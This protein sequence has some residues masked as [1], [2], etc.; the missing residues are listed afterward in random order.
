LTRVRLRD[1][2]ELALHEQ[3]QGPA[4]L[5]VHGF[6]GSQRA[7]GDAVIGALAAHGRVLAVDLLGHGASDR[8]HRAQRYDVR[9]VVA[10]LCDA[11]AARGA[12][13][14]LWIGYS[15]GARVALAAAV[16]APARVAGLVLEGGSPGLEQAAER[17]A[18]RAADAALAERLEREGIE[19]FVAHWMD[20]AIFATQRRLPARTR[21]AERSRRLAN[22]PLALAAC[23]RGLGTGAQ[24]SFWSSL[25]VIRAPALLVAG[26]HDAKYRELAV[27]MAARLPRAQ[28]AV[29][30][31]A[32][33]AAHLEEPERYLEAVLPHVERLQRTRME[34]SEGGLHPAGPTE[35]SPAR[36]E[37][38]AS[39]GGRHPAGRTREGATS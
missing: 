5:L 30:A 10:D 12:A 28:V 1:G 36:S 2:L 8:P 16:L 15:Q 25:A 26:E 37:P 38:E 29:I 39:E 14:A 34:A 4:L 6:T 20:L 22:D 13:D 24:P 17:S 7:W 35:A 18:R 23:L 3:G 21:D 31:G 19:P 11:L 27:A 33:H 9:E 32:G